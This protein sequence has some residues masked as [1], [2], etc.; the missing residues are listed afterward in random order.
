MLKH[1]RVELIGL[2]VLV[3]AGLLWAQEQV[4]LTTYYPSPRGVYRELRVGSG[5]ATSPP[6]RLHVVK[7]E[8]DGDFAFRVDDEGRRRF[9]PAGLGGE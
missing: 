5:I 6:A 4:T 1:W 8:D 9:F 2:L 7:P 3:G